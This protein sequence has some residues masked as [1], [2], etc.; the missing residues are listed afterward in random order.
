MKKTTS[1]GAYYTLTAE[2]RHPD[3]LSCNN[4]IR[5]DATSFEEILQLV[6]PLITHKENHMKSN[7]PPSERL[8]VTLGYL[9]CFD[10]VRV[11]PLPA[12]CGSRW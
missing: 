12:V 2:V 9:A 1:F 4:F 11:S 6:A 3:F 10:I 8:A 7:I 5:M